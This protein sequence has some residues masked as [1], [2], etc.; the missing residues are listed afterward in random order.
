MLTRDV[1]LMVISY[2][3]T[4]NLHPV[5][6]PPLVVNNQL[7]RHAS[8]LTR[9]GDCPSGPPPTMPSGCQSGHASHTVGNVMTNVAT[10]AHASLRHRMR[11]LLHPSRVRKREHQSAPSIC[12]PT[13]PKACPRRSRSSQR[14]SGEAGEGFHAEVDP[15]LI[16]S[17]VTSVHPQNH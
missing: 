15:K 5:S 14:S 11:T 16:N 10:G 12:S 9:K 2:K 6:S 7:P 3:F 13:P 17:L 8:P 1:L 4:N